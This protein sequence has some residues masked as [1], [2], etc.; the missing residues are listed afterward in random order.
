MTASTRGKK[1]KAEDSDGPQETSKGGCEE[2]QISLTRSEDVWFHDGNL[3]LVAGSVAFK[4]YKGIITQYSSVFDET[5]SRALPKGAMDDCPIV[6]LSD[7]SSDLSILLMA[8]FDSAFGFFSDEQTLDFNHISAMLRLGSKYKITHICAEAIR[9]L[10]NCFPEDLDRYVSKHTSSYVLYPDSDTAYTSYFPTASIDLQ[11]EH[12]IAVINLARIYGLDTILPAVFY[13]A[14]QLP[15]KTIIHG[16]DDGETIWKLDEDDLERC[17]NG[18]AML[19]SSMQRTFFW[20]FDSIPDACKDRKNCPSALRINRRDVWKKYLCRPDALL[21]SGRLDVEL[22]NKFCPYCTYRVKVAHDK[23][24]E[25]TW[26]NLREYFDIMPSSLEED[27]NM[28]QDT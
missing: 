24:R 26:N 2:E 23:Q 21:D 17:L 19:K 11:H 13:A 28:E 22:H 20:L 14:A 1:R 27:E 15:L 18:Q 9:R 6:H 7:T 3:V 10:K 4:V 5:F 25:V 8:I 12:C 16:Y